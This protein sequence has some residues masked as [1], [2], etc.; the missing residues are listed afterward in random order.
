MNEL[1]GLRVTTHVARDLLQSADLFRHPERVVWEYVANGLEYSDS[2]V[3][4]LV[5]VAIQSNPKRVV[6]SDNGRGMDRGGLVQ[7]F[8]MHAE[9]QDRL[10]GRPGRGFFGTGKSAAFAIANVLRIAT[11]KNGKRSVVELR[12][13]DLEEASSGDPVPVRELAIEAPVSLPNGTTVTIED[14]RITKLNRSD[15]IKAVERHLR[16]WGRGVRVEVDGL[17]VEPHVPPISFTEKHV[18]SKDEF[19][20]LEGCELVL[21]VSKAPLLEEDRGVAILANGTLHETTLG[22]AKGKPMSQYI[23]GELEVPA[24]AQPYKGVAAFDMSRSG[25]LNPENEI[26]L[27]TYAGI[28]RHVEALRQRLVESEKQRKSAEE[29]E[30][31]QAQADEIAR[32]INQDYADYSKRFRPVPTGGSGATD[33]RPSSKSHGEGEE[34]FL[35]EGEEPAVEVNEDIVPIEPQD[36]TI[37]PEP[38]EPTPKVEPADPEAADTTGHTERRAPSKR[39]PTGGFTVQFRENGS[40]AAR[41]FYERETRT[42]FINLDHPQVQAAKGDAE[43]DEPNFKRLSYEIAFTEY[44]IG[45]AQENATNNYYTDFYE[46]LF[47][48]RDRIDSLARKA[49]NVFRSS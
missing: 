7:F 49:A 18:F 30:K 27:A 19:E 1:K 32:L 28:S 36:N 17:E 23:F 2:G 43:V 44:A 40:E 31:L 48:M 34:V 12:R 47:D 5:R 33:L 29:A 22:T 15:I 11:V 16:H 42:I 41:A 20:H 6:I 14:F 37:G 21:H 26:V 9:N 45:F 39:H 10:S 13:S 4:P 24:L 35:P 38:R 46:P 3:Q 8:T 25:Q